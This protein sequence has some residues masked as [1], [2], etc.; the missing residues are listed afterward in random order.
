M[1]LFGGLLARRRS[2]ADAPLSHQKTVTVAFILSARRSGSTWLNLVLGS[3]SWAMN[4]GEYYR[5]FTMP[6][7]V[8]CRLCE[9]DGLKD[10]TVLGGIEGVAVGDAFH[11][12]AARSG[13]STLV[14]ASKDLDWCRRFLGVEGIDARIIHLVRHPCGYVESEGRRS[15]LSPAALLAEWEE[16]NRGIEAFVATAGVPAML[17]D[18][19]DLADAPEKFLPPLCAFLGHDFEPAALAYWN[20][21]HHGLGGNGAASVYLKKHP[22]HRFVT[23]DDRFYAG[24]EERPTSADRRWKDRLPRDF[25]IAAIATPYAAGLARRLGRGT[26]E[27]PA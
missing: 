3:H 14:D 10:C 24:V 22:N 19:D 5:P 8:A 27:R 4:L 18:Y 11:F 2:D 16:V 17:A 21:P 12:A 1:G 6:G 13:K 15:A 25:C 7:H 9:A 20:F 26:F 23:G